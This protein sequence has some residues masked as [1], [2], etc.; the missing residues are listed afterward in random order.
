MAPRQFDLRAIGTRLRF[1]QRAAYFR[2]LLKW[3]LLGSVVG[4][5]AG[6]AAALFLA[7]LE[8]VTTIRLAN[9]WLLFLLPAAGFAISWVYLKFGRTSGRGNNLILDELFEFKENLPRRMAPL[10][11]I[12]TVVG[13]L[14]GASVGREGTAV[15][16]GA[17]LADG[18]RRLLGLNAD[19]R[20]LMLMAGISGGF[21]AVFGTPAAGAIFGM[22]VQSIGRTRYD[23]LIPCVTASVIGDLTA[24]ALGATHTLTP[25]LPAIDL[26][27][28]LLV[29]MVIAGV[30]FGLCALAFIELTHLVKATQARMIAYAPYRPVI[31]ALV[32]I[33]LTLL[34]GTHDYLGLSIPLIGDALD[35][36]GVLPLAFL[37]KLVF[38][39]ICLGSGFVGGEVTPLFVMGATLGYTLGGVLGVDTTLMAAAG[40]VAVFAAASNTPLTC[41]VLGMEL[42]GGGALAYILIAC[43]VAYVS[44]GHRSIYASQ[45]VGT[46]KMMVSSLPRDIT[47][48]S[49]R[50]EREDRHDHQTVEN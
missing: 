35:G 46:P 44:S 20:R 47:L 33:A 32:I 5:V 4:V 31:G 24:R 27:A 18:L 45:L 28:L 9:A 22:E 16:M 12:G 50:Q 19:D 48:E 36:T 38:T 43:V 26:D 34:L 10:V 14:F 37:A 39:A 1:A 13:H 8:W 15:Q 23:G 3:L 49:Y 42:F 7:A 6:A 41:V 2:T 25:Q 29:K 30:L 11:L 21:G 40:F 17:S